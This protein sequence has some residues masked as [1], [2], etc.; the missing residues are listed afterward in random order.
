MPR[1]QQ[2]LSRILF[3]SQ[4]DES[5]KG[6]LHGWSPPGTCVF[7]WTQNP[8]QSPGAGSEEK[9]QVGGGSSPLEGSAG[10]EKRESRLLNFL[11]LHFLTA[12]ETLAGD[13]CF[14]LPLAFRA[15]NL[16]KCTL[17]SCNLPAE[18]STLRRNMQAS[19]VHE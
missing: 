5:R 17:P 16:S 10:L 3:V 1:T 12:H 2:M 4:D 14:H 13:C 8:G 15:L 7:S 6:R 19:H 9:A 18:I 11:V